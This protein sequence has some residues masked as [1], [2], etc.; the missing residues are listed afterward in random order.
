MQVGKGCPE[1]KSLAIVKSNR[2]FLTAKWTLDLA[3]AP[4]ERHQNHLTG[5][6]DFPASAR[7][8]EW[9]WI[10]VRSAPWQ[11][12][13]EAHQILREHA[14]DAAAGAVNV[15]DEKERYA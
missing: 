15:R 11:G 1:E 4:A 3:N 12:L 14:D 13:R 6:P 5:N 7:R 9:R 8:P 10:G 2:R